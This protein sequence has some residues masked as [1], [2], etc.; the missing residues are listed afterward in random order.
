MIAISLIFKSIFLTSAWFASLAA[1]SSPSGVSGIVRRRARCDRVSQSGTRALPDALLRAVLFVLAASK[2]T[3]HLKV[4][5]RRPRSL[6]LG[7]GCYSFRKAAIGSILSVLRAGRYIAA[8]TA[9][10]RAAGTAR[11]TTGSMELTPQ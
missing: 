1:T 11:N 7:N 3:L 4:R 9:T 10:P 6:V 5:A 8:P 2:L